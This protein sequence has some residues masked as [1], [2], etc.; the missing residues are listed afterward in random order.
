VDREGNSLLAGRVGGTPVVSMNG[1]R[2]VG[3]GHNSVFR[4][5]AGQWWTAYHAVDR[6]DPYFESEPGFTK[7]PVLLDPVDWVDGWPTVRAGRWASDDPMPAP[8][9]QPGEESAYTPDPVQQDE[10]AAAL[11]AYSDEFD[12]DAL[13]PSWTWVRR[14]AEGTYGNESGAFR[15]D[16]QAADLHVDNNSASVLTRPAP[17]GDYMVETR[18][19]LTVPPEGCCFNYVQAG[20]VVYG[21]DDSYVKLTHA[22]I[23]ETRQT[24]FAKEVPVADAGA[25]RYGN[26][27]VGAPADWTYLRI[28]RRGTGAHEEYTAYTSQDGDRW[29]RGGTWTHD[30]GAE[31]RIGLVSMG[32]D[33]FTAR[34]DHVRVSRVA[35]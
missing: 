8:A 19:R 26:T 21:G 24:E 25:P 7:R 22:S 30:L 9:A 1:N 34:F 15:L 29:V 4:D 31:P 16:T 20:L 28:V 35:P 18:V 17:E 11:P 6:H 32:G 13:D 5:L 23:W 2:W 3:T 33:G 27:V 12:G 14:P 10:A